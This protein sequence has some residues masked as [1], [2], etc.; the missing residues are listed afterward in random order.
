MDTNAA[1]S[2]PLELS[3]VVPTF[4]EAANIPILAERVFGALA[5]ANIQ[6]ELILV[7]DDSRDGTDRAVAELEKRFPVKLITRVGE[8]GLSSAVLRGFT[9]ARGRVLLVM[10]ADLQHPPDRVVEVSRPIREGTADFA[11]GSRYVAGAEMVNWRFYRKLNSLVATW[12]ALPL[13]GVRDPMSGFFSLR[14]ETWQ[15]A[16]DRMNPIGYKIALE[17]LVKCRCRNVVEV[18]ITFGD[19]VHGESKLNARQ[20]L[21]YLQHLAR[22][23]RFRYPLLF[24]GTILVAA[25]LLVYGIYAAFAS[26]SSGSAP[27]P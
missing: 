26:P 9:E 6:G 4:R 12:L 3:V 16:A 18:P 14:R 17:L 27:R 21:Q 25:A 8:R 22:L 20:Q 23:Y 1:Q 11:L 2:P 7:D 10:D 24:F 13:T 5:A 19:R 15:A